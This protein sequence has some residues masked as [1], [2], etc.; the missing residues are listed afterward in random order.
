L[1]TN[2]RFPP[3]KELL[4]PKHQKQELVLPRIQSIMMGQNTVIS[5]D[6]YLRKSKTMKLFNCPTL[7]QDSR[8]FILS[9]KQFLGIA[10]KNSASSLDSVIYIGLNLREKGANPIGIT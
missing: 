4:L 6:I 8:L 5:I 3:N 9:Q 7:K 2:T 1:N 10:L